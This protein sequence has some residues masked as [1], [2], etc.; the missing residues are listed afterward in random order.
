MGTGIRNCTNPLQVLR[1]GTHGYQTIKYL[2]LIYHHG[3]QKSTT[4]VI[5][6]NHGFHIFKTSNSC[7]ENCWLFVGFFHGAWRFFDGFKIP[8]TNGSLILIIFKYLDPVV[9]WFW[10]F[11]IPRTGGSF[12]LIYIY[13]YMSNSWNLWLLQKIKDPLHTSRNLLEFV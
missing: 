13:I 3:Y 8:R 12:I 5:T 4:L 11:Q 10:F 1:V 2:V 6:C 9:L 7:L